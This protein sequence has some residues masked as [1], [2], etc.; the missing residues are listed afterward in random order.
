MSKFSL[1]LLFIACFSLVNAQPSGYKIAKDLN[2]FKTKFNKESQSIFSITSDFTQTKNLKMLAEKIVSKGQF[3]FKKN[4]K[5]RMEYLTPYKYLLVINNNTIY[6]KKDNKLNTYSAKSNKAFN[7]INKLILEC[8]QGTVINNK[9]FNTSLFENETIFLL[10]LIPNKKEMK[11]LFQTIQ[12]YI[13]KK[14]Y[15]VNKLNLIEAS[16]DNTEL[17]FTNK[18]INP[19]L[20]DD[21]Y[22]L[23]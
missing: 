3:S 4:N 7:Q 10:Q 9:D 20:S 1:S 17:Q 5:V 15:T 21:I 12:I 2:P 16:G 14:N 6:I 13:D 11:N 8:V 19:T 18:N 23:K 22:I